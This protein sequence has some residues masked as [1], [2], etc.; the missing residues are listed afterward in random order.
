MI[1]TLEAYDQIRKHFGQDRVLAIYLEV[2]DSLRLERALKREQ[3]QEEPK[4]TE[5]CRRFLADEKDFSEENL[6][7]Y[8]IYKSYRNEDIN[9]CISEIVRS[10][11][12]Y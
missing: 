1:G 3:T 5:L 4:Y 6:A 7:K 10:I 12:N 11:K 9:A 8:K 2:E